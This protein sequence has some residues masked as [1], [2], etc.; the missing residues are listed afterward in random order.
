MIHGISKGKV[1]KKTTTTTTTSVS[2]NKDMVKKNRNHLLKPQKLESRLIKTRVNGK[3]R[4]RRKKIDI[5]IG[6]SVQ[7]PKKVVLNVI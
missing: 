3:S 5:Y 1:E 4:R 2:N 7:Q 6:S